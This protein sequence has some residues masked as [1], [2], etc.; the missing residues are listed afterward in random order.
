MA[1]Y[2]QGCGTLYL[3]NAGAEKSAKEARDAFQKADTAALFQHAAS[4]L[5]SDLTNQQDAAQR[6]VAAAQDMTLALLIEGTKDKRPWVELDDIVKPRLKSLLGT[7]DGVKKFLERNDVDALRT[8]HLTNLRNIEKDRLNLE[9][10][11]K[12]YGRVGTAKNRCQDQDP[13]AHPMDEQPPEED[14]E[15][16]KTIYPKLEKACIE[17][18]KLL[19]VEEEGRMIGLDPKELKGEVGSAYEM[20]KQLEHARADLKSAQEELKKEIDKLKRKYD[21]ALAA[22]KQN[23]KATA[24]QTDLKQAATAL[25]DYL[26]DIEDAEKVVDRVK[27]ATQGKVN[28]APIR[29]ATD[30]SVGYVGDL[31]QAQVLET[32][33]NALLTQAI[34]PTK[35]PQTDAEKGAQ[36]Y[37]LLT[38]RAVDAFARLQDVSSD[39]TKVPSPN[40]LLIGIA[41]ERYRQSVARTTEALIEQ[42]IAAR[43]AEFAATIE[44]L[45]QLWMA[46]K[47]AEEMSKASCG[48]GT[49]GFSDFVSRCK[50]DRNAEQSAAKALIFY[51]RAWSL[52][53]AEEISA[54]MTDS[55]ARLQYAVEMARVS[56]QAWFDLLSPAIQELVAY[57]EGGLRQETIANLIN[58]LGLGAIAVGVNK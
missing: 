12:L 34:D 6:Q 55:A 57:G 30:V 9:K 15:G 11:G 54:A 52:G 39:P 21:I 31:V 47:A 8:T 40:A 37:L 16:A 36:T 48:Q 32:N 25:T 19:D 22:A 5:K 27:E 10:F 17:F 49:V 35:A 29:R 24:L 42:R 58:A 7:D 46:A 23:P 20:L 3:H 26:K 38:I 51:D 53:Q 1:I 41:Y 44:E 43:S 4:E 13:R 56:A 45:Y 14:S 33:L 2:L 50:G 28:L 18:A